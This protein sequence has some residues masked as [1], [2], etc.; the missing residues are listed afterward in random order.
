MIRYIF[1]R[2]LGLSILACLS[3][4]TSLF[5]QPTQ[6]AMTFPD[7]LGLQYEEH[8]FS[9]QVGEL[10]GW[11]L[12]AV[13]KT[14]KTILFAH[15]NAGNISTHIGFVYW[16][17][18]QGYNV[19]MFDYRGY[20]RSQGVPSSEGIVQDMQ[21]AMVW[22]ETE[23]NIPPQSTVL[24]AHSLGAAATI[25]AIAERSREPDYIDKSYAGVI[26][27][28]AFKD[29]RS[30]AKS[31]LKQRWWT[32]W[33]RPIVPLLITSKPSSEQQI[34]RIQYTPM[35]L[36][37]SKEDAVVPYAHSQVLFEQTQGDKRFYTVHNP[38]HNH[39]WQYAKD[40]QWFL[41]QLSEFYSTHSN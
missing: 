35:R 22:L 16:L 21:S 11:W 12:P 33:L 4:C 14:N 8:L 9:G 37:H 28:S 25:P 17:P 40:R 19:F 30:V 5:F 34:K 3:G 2:V 7:Q 24:Y 32:T 39:G 13:K 6:P 18:K 31:T 41:E 15:G 1:T 10:Y 23:K 36:A 38:Q 20:G 26:L 27:D 29:Y